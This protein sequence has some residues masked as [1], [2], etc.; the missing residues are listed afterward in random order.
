MLHTI[1][2]QL[3]LIA[4]GLVCVLAIWKGSPAERIGA[5]LVALTWGGLLLVQGVTGEAV[6]QIPLL[7][8]D[9]VLATGF[10]VLAI[11]Y[12][13]TWLGA[14]MLFQ[15]GAFALHLARMNAEMREA[16]LYVTGI[17]ALS[18]CVLACLA[19][20]AIMSWMARRRKA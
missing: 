9:A 10:L 15:A 5:I 16:R 17:N 14:G 13:S 2:S 1:T 8:S 12:A 20:G 4:L 11:R 19:G 6:P 3:G 18:Y 7:I